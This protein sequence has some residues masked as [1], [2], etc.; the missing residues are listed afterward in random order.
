ME[1]PVIRWTGLIRDVGDGGKP[2]SP[3]RDVEV[4]QPPPQAEQSSA[5]RAPAPAAVLPER[6]GPA[7]P[8]C[9]LHRPGQI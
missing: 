3:R 6:L 8:P 7:H 1:R 5:R 2:A 9:A 4:L